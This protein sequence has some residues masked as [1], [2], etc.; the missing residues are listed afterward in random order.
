MYVV[1]WLDMT[2][3]VP[4][5]EREEFNDIDIAVKRFREIKKKDSSAIL[6]DSYE[7]RDISG[8]LP[9]EPVEPLNM[10]ELARSF[11]ANIIGK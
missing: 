4:Q 10:A 3:D 2:A 7:M 6:F 5:L 1:S 9:P 11:W 8:E